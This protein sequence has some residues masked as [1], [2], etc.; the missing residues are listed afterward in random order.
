VPQHLEHGGSIV[1]PLFSGGRLIGGYK[2]ARADWEASRAAYEQTTLV[3]FQEVSD[4]L[5]AIDRLRV[6]HDELARAVVALG[7]AYRLARLRFVDGLASYFEVLEAQQ[8]LFP[9]ELALA[10]SSATA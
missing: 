9:A 7:D 6:V 5:I 1:G 4:A 3:A 2:A 8:E 10:A